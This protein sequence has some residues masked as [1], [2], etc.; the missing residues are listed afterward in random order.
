V[1]ERADGG[2]AKIAAGDVFAFAGHGQ[3]RTLARPG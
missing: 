1:L 2:I 3:A